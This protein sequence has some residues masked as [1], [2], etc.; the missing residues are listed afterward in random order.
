MERNN[1]SRLQ[2]A[3]ALVK[4][5]FSFKG[6]AS[7]IEFAIV[8]LGLPM[9]LVVP[10]QM[11]SMLFINSND[12]YLDFLWS[13]IPG[14]FWFW[15]IFAVSARRA[16][17][18]GKSGWYSAL[19]FVPF[20]NFVA[21]IY[22]VATDGQPF[23]NQY[24]P[25]T[26]N[27]ISPIETKGEASIVVSQQKQSLLSRLFLFKGRAKRT[28]YW[29]I[30]LCSFTLLLPLF[31]MDKTNETSVKIISSYLNYATTIIF[32]LILSVTARRLHDMNHSGWYSLLIF[33][34]FI[35]FVVPIYLGFFKGKDVE[36]KYGPS[37]Y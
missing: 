35:N 12:P 34:P 32:W 24:G 15:T 21:L 22:G 11:I 29:L 23:D 8:F 5:L 33:V 30:P 18:L 31:F 17:D 9:L 36:N 6:R 10:C 2:Q 13:L 28:E 37:P 26:G 3:L 20:L 14:V 7:R 4:R 1:N 19:L 16:H 25:A 27:K